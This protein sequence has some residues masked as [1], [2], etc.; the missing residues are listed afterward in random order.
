[1]SLSWFAWIRAIVAG[2]RV[3]LAV[4]RAVA[5]VLSLAVLSTGLDSSFRTEGAE[6]EQAPSTNQTPRVVS[7]FL[8]PGVLR[9]SGVPQR[10]L[11]I[12][13]GVDVR[14]ELE[15]ARATTGAV[16][17]GVLRSV[18]GRE[19]GSAPA[20]VAGSR[21]VAVGLN[22]ASFQ[23]ADYILM[24]QAMQPGATDQT[25]EAYAFSVV[26]KE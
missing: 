7:V 19:V 21:T 10:R 2:I 24:L 25:L 23:N 9:G 8:S 26:R 13:P 22:E 4:R 3:S 18:G 6:Q 14:L 20:V 5:T 11:S 17:R 16:Y 1:M 15:Y 12:P